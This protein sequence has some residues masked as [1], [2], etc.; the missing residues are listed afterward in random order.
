MTNH[1][2]EKVYTLYQLNKAFK[3]LVDPNLE[4]KHFGWIVRFLM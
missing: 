2:Q 4:L 3:Q 1:T